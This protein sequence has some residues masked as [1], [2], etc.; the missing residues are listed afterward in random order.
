MEQH[1]KKEKIKKE[2]N[3]NKYLINETT[4]LKFSKY[5]TMLPNPIGSTKTP[6]VI[7]RLTNPLSEA[8]MM[9]I[10]L[11]QHLPHLGGIFSK[12]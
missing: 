3:G 11:Y 1:S 9:P 5:Y 2:R 8:P 6:I 12:A 4:S 7:L 10:E